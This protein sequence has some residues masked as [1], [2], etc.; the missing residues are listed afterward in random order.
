MRGEFK[1]YEAEDYNSMRQEEFKKKSLY[2]LFLKY[3]LHVVFWKKNI[4]L[5]PRD[6]E[7][8]E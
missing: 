6:S 3:I 4:R 8:I 7:S 5:F 1:E 2:F